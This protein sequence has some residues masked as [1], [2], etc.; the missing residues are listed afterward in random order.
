MEKIAN[1]TASKKPSKFAVDTLPIESW[2]ALAKAFGGEE[3]L[4]PANNLIQR[5]AKNQRSAGN[6][7]LSVKPAI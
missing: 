4:E 7:S 3:K 5:N 2:R 6:Q 1:Q